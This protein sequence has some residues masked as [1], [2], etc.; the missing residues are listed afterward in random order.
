MPVYNAS[1]FLPEA[2]DSILQQT[3]TDFEFLIID[4]GSVDGTSTIIE[5]YNDTR[6]KHI[7]LPVNGG[8]VNA[9]NKG[10]SLA[11]GEYIVR[12]DGDDIA[13]ST[14]IE[15]Q[16]AFMDTHPEIGAA[17]SWVTY[18]GAKNGL[19]KQPSTHE[20][21]VWAL[22]FGSA[23]FHPSVILRADTIRNLSLRYPENYPHAEDYAFWIELSRKTKLANIEEP[24]LNYR[25]TNTS[26]TSVHS[27][28]Q[29]KS[30]EKLQRLMHEI[31]LGNVLDDQKWSLL[32]SGS[33]QTVDISE[34]YHVY[35]VINQRNKL[36]SASVFRK[37]IRYLVRSIVAKRHISGASKFWLLSR[38]YQNLSY[39][40]YFMM[41]VLK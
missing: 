35:N 30:A 17:G 21:I 9:L 11:Q 40:R 4:D 41:A 23:I 15:R 37:K 8:I 26:V 16:V 18:F 27:N 13:V 24:L 28:L 39:L 14:R 32:L 29:R 2:I 3:L 20:E 36:F 33:S 10:L 22:L 31:L 25:W 38:A 12:M 1:A 19:M 5:G 34:V 7:K 6:I